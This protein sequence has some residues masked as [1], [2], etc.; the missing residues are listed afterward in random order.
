MSEAAESDAA[1][2]EAGDLPSFTEE[3]VAEGKT[4]YNASCSVCHGDSLTNN[5]YGPPLAGEFFQAN[6]E[7]RTG[8]ELVE[9]VHTM[10]PSA[11][12]SLSAE[13][14]AALTAYILSVNGLPAGPEPM[15]TR[16][17]GRSPRG[18]PASGR[19]TRSARRR[20]TRGR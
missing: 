1:P 19:R 17:G 18:R 14:Y 6:W 12:D 8:G 11:P 16:S 20:P 3:Q 5:T 15:T 7:G 4:A 10:P 2:V 9:K 13:T